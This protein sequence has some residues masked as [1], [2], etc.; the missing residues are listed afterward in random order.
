M[1]TRFAASLGVGVGIAVFLAGVVAAVLGAGH[2]PFDGFR[3]G[4]RGFDG[5]RVSFSDRGQDARVVFSG[6]V[7]A[8]EQDHAEPVLA[9]QHAHLDP[10]RGWQVRGQVC[11]NH[12][13]LRVE[14]DVAVA[15]IAQRAVH[16]SVHGLHEL[17]GLGRNRPVGGL[18]WL[19]Q[20]RVRF[21]MH[22]E[23]DVV[24]IGPRDEAGAIRIHPIASA[25]MRLRNSTAATCASV[26]SS[27][28][29][30]PS[31]RSVSLCD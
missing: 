5:G 16:H 9:G 30:T 3:V 22:L 19:S 10:V 18:G 27:V 7:P 23:V 26:G 31:T 25:E 15:H 14:I 8:N 29:Q 28:S 11:A 20:E 1:S 12:P 17:D 2:V 4:Y 6:D 13:S 21:G 24:A